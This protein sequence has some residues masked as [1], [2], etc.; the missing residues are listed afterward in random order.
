VNW[1]ILGGVVLAFVLLSV[2]A[3]YIG[4]SSMGDP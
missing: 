1:K 2:L 3:A 4:L